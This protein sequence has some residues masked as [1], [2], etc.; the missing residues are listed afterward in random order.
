MVDED[1]VPLDAHFFVGLAGVVA[2]GAFIG[3]SFAG[4][5]SGPWQVFGWCVWFA[6][7]IV[8]SRWKRT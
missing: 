5:I 4:K 7:L 2:F 1:D 3:V 8:L 6:F